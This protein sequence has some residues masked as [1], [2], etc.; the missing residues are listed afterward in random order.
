MHERSNLCGS[1]VNPG[2]ENIN[3]VE[4]MLDDCLEGTRKTPTRLE[5]M[6]C[7]DEDL[8]L[9]C[10]RVSRLYEYY[11]SIDILMDDLDM[12][13][14]NSRVVARCLERHV[15]RIEMDR[16][17]YYKSS[18]MVNSSPS[19]AES[20][21][22]CP[23]Y[24]LVNSLPVKVKVHLEAGDVD[25]EYD[26]LLS[27]LGT[28]YSDEDLGIVDVKKFAHE[29]VEACEFY[30]GELYK[31]SMEMDVDFDFVDLESS[32]F[33]PSECCVQIMNERLTLGSV[34]AVL[35]M[36]RLAKTEFQ[37]FRVFKSRSG[38]R[39]SDKM[40]RFLRSTNDA[41]R[42]VFVDVIKSR[43]GKNVSCVPRKIESRQKRRDAKESRFVE[44][45]AP[46]GDKDVVPRRKGRDWGVFL[47]VS[48]ILISHVGPTAGPE[49]KELMIGLQT[50]I[51]LLKSVRTADSWLGVYAA[52]TGFASMM[53]F[54]IEGFF[55]ML[56]DVPAELGVKFGRVLKTEPMSFDLA[57]GFDDGVNYHDVDGSYGYVSF[58]K[59]HVL[60]LNITPAVFKMRANVHPGAT[61]ATRA[62][63]VRRYGEPPEGSEYYGLSDGCLDD[64]ED[65]GSVLLEAPKSK[66]FGKVRF[67]ALYG[68]ME[69]LLG[70]GMSLTLAK[71]LSFGFDPA[72]LLMVTRDSLKSSI[73][74]IVELLVAVLRAFAEFDVWKALDVLKSHFFGTDANELSAFGLRLKEISE[75]D[76]MPSLSAMA[77]LSIIK[78]KVKIIRQSSVVMDK[79]E[80][81]KVA[82][83]MLGQ[84]DAAIETRRLRHC[85]GHVKTPP[86]LFIGHKD[87]RSGKSLIPIAIAAAIGSAFNLPLD[88]TREITYYPQTGSEYYEGIDHHHMAI[89]RDEMGSL[90][91]DIDKNIGAHAG[92][93][94]DLCSAMPTSL[95]MAFEGKGKVTTANIK[96]VTVC[97]NATAKKFCEVYSQRAAILGRGVWVSVVTDPSI[98]TDGKFDPIKIKD[99]T[100]AELDKVVYFEL[101]KGHDVPHKDI[102]WTDLGTYTMTGFIQY[103]A[104]EMRRSCSGG[105]KANV[106]RM[107]ASVS[108][109]RVDASKP[110]VCMKRTLV[111][112]TDE[113]EVMG[114][115]DGLVFPNL[116]ELQTPFGFLTRLK[117]KKKEAL[118]EPVAP[119]S[120]VSSGVSPPATP[121]PESVSVRKGWFLKSRKYLDRKAWD[122]K[123][124]FV[125]SGMN[126]A[127]RVVAYDSWT[128]FNLMVQKLKEYAQKALPFIAGIGL[129]SYVI[130]RQ[131]TYDS[132][133]H[134]KK[135]KVGV[136]VEI[137]LPQPIRKEDIDKIPEA[138]LREWAGEVFRV[139]PSP[140]EESRVFSLHNSGVMTVS[141]LD[142]IERHHV[143]VQVTPLDGGSSF[144]QVCGYVWDGALVT[145]GH[146][147][148]RDCKRAR[149]VAY[150]YLIPRAIQDFELDRKHWEFVDGC[151]LVVMRCVLPPGAKDLKDVLKGGSP[152]V[153]DRAIL[154]SCGGMPRLEGTIVSMESVSYDLPDK[155]EQTIDRCV[156]TDIT[157]TQPGH[158]G[159]VLVA[160]TK[161]GIALA[162]VHFGR[163]KETGGSM[164]SYVD[165]E[166]LSRV[167]KKLK[168]V[169]LQGLM[170]EDCT[171][172]VISHPERVEP[173]Y[174]DHGV[175]ADPFFAKKQLFL[176][177]AGV[178]G[179]AKGGKSR[180][181]RTSFYDS[182]EPLLEEACG[183]VFSPAVLS[184][185]YRYDEDLDTNRKVSPYESCLSYDN[186]PVACIPLS[187]LD[188][189][190]EGA[191]SVC[192]P[193][194]IE[195]NSMV[196]FDEALNSFAT[197]KCVDPTTGASM[198][199]PGKKGKFMVE[200]AW[201]GQTVRVARDE[202]RE[203]S[204]DI[205]RRLLANE[206]PCGVSKVALKDEVLKSKKIIGV[207]TRAVH[208]IA[209]D[210][211]NNNRMFFG[212]TIEKV[213][214]E[215]QRVF[216]MCFTINAHGKD[217]KWVYNRSVN[218]EGGR[219]R[220]LCADFEKFDVHHQYSVLVYAMLFFQEL[221]CRLWV[222]PEK[223]KKAGCLLL[224]L[225]IRRLTFVDG[226][227]VDSFMGGPSG[228]L[229][230]VFFNCVCQMFYWFICWRD[231]R[232][233]GSF[234][235][236]MKELAD[237]W[238]SLGDD[239]SLAIPVEVS[240]WF[241]PSKIVES[242]YKRCGQKITGAGVK[243]ELRYDD[244][245]VFLKRTFRED[246]ER[247]VAP[248]LVSSLLKSLLYLDPKAGSGN[249]AMRNWQVLCMVHEE[250]LFHD[251]ETRAYLRNLVAKL[252]VEL[253]AKYRDVPFPSDE[254]LWKRFDEGSMMLWDRFGPVGDA[255][256]RPVV[257]GVQHIELQC[258]GSADRPLVDLCW[259]LK[260]QEKAVFAGHRCLA[261]HDKWRTEDSV[262]PTTAQG[263]D[264]F[265]RQS[266]VFSRSAAFNGNDKIVAAP[267]SEVQ[268]GQ[269]A[270]VVTDDAIEDTAGVDVSA[271]RIIMK[272]NSSTSSMFPFG[273]LA[274][275]DPFFERPINIH[276]FSI[277]S[278]T[279]ESEINP[280][281]EYFNNDMVFNRMYGFCNVRFDLEITI[282]VAPSPY[283]YGLCRVWWF[284]L[285][286][287]TQFGVPV[288][289]SYTRGSQC[290]G[291]WIDFA[292]A[293][294]KSFVIKWPYWRDAVDIT[295]NAIFSDFGSLILT[296]VVP[297]RRVDSA[298]SGIIPLI[299][300]A[301]A[302]NMM[303][304]GPTRTEVQ[305]QSGTTDF[306]P[307][308]GSLRVLSKAAN[309]VS[310]IPF[311][312][313]LA[314]GA[315]AILDGMAT[316]AAWFGFSRKLDEKYRMIFRP[317][318][319]AGVD[320]KDDA[321]SLS[322]SQSYG[323][324]GNPAELSGVDEDEMSLLYVASRDSTVGFVSWSSADA[325]D[326]EIFRTCVSPFYCT[327]WNGD[328]GILYKSPCAVGFVAQPFAYWRGT[329]IFSFRIVCSNFH[330]G[331]I[332]LVYDPAVAG[333]AAST[334]PIEQS[335]SC[336]LEVKPGAVVEMEIGWS[337]S[338]PWLFTDVGF[339]S[340]PNGVGTNPNGFIKAYV[341]GQLTSPLTAAEAYIV[342]SVRAGKDFRVCSSR[343]LP[344]WTTDQGPDFVASRDKK[345]VKEIVKTAVD[346]QSAIVN[347]VA[348]VGYCS[349]GS[350]PVSDDFVDQQTFGERIVSMRALL[351]RYQYL[352]DLVSDE[353]GTAV[354]S[355][356][357]FSTSFPIA[358]TMIGG[359]EY[360][361]GDSEANPVTLQN[362]TLFRYFKSL[363]KGHRGGTRIR[364]R[365][366]THTVA[367]VTPPD[368][369]Y[370]LVLSDAASGSS[371]DDISSACIPTGSSAS[372]VVEEAKN[373][374][375]D[376]RL[377]D[378]NHQRFI[379]GGAFKPEPNDGFGRFGLTITRPVQDA[380]LWHY[381]LSRAIDEDFS[382]IGFCGAPVL[383][384]PHP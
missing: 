367:G 326:D 124:Y 204:F 381:S 176:P 24:S 28:Y 41:W 87:A 373:Q 342:C 279:V 325:L 185:V 293:G 68:L 18:L 55:D 160:E 141:G 181:V 207:N 100:V 253:S 180:L 225:V 372:E 299:V 168:G 249:I 241:T 337:N 130:S 334:A 117:K 159:R 288:S 234:A 93:L 186:I 307:V 78:T 20:V 123:R 75:D 56:G 369:I 217:W 192:D 199:T 25:S 308:S 148:P 63:L 336:I 96:A 164:S 292:Q 331:S 205:V 82:D 84:L 276:S 383:Q 22:C 136:D 190:L 17:S 64:P 51:Q 210:E 108:N 289:T 283:Q 182:V 66:D 323:I 34:V 10:E 361:G 147:L 300:R 174:P 377:P 282:R 384:F 137:K 135:K 213:Y 222:G 83:A 50:L 340:F 310:E 263:L 344:N 240:L 277:D 156:K 193:E 347:N 94:L 65:T 134:P 285:K 49:W 85:L 133:D 355:D 203:D 297:M 166:K 59:S 77:E 105:D 158:C 143:I 145:V 239:C 112:K 264:C 13:D 45:Q 72:A 375:A 345:A 81:V 341:L 114:A 57:E 306:K 208:A 162:G 214:A 362:A 371:V 202:L 356:K 187:S 167:A 14:Y 7:V 102:Q 53:D 142:K 138:E 44:L 380:T 363:Y 144:G 219:R 281:R 238:N 54:S 99:K 69:T 169:E 257:A 26:D 220:A 170:F 294:A 232:G 233:G 196:G 224:W 216:G 4:C 255:T 206:V 80:L 119:V 315:A 298:S 171:F 235:E 132:D 212:K 320:S 116:I 106:T 260:V 324:M 38:S 278:S 218:L 223:V 348:A 95:N 5:S 247:L 90:N 302:I 110:P 30:T 177:V 246:G 175:F 353:A 76:K 198:A 91:Q 290:D 172:G 188:D 366:L 179:N 360:F 183:D 314:K 200:V 42:S 274:D 295:E 111:G 259:V 256:I 40:V 230:T 322:Y 236:F 98:H 1:F 304:A 269:V 382:F 161:S 157:E 43:T 29:H 338:A 221:F 303:R 351:K 58:S 248:L 52:I 35:N 270:T 184:S 312:G 73:S 237:H 194:P 152:S 39:A 318:G 101:A 244:E 36:P 19:I 37:Q 154:L 243:G 118:T 346:L 211:Y 352:G 15:E 305:L 321:L 31:L 268:V 6:S 121:K 173:G 313:S 273:E 60:G 151:D 227:W 21:L 296:P 319:Y 376:F 343:V 129:A 226:A 16:R 155:T 70:A 329:L 250:A 291:V 62:W 261:Q 97:T 368:P 339:E 370:R 242:M 275:Y 195:G 287:I 364:V 280:F 3:S 215:L 189:C 107:F 254:V 316:V 165:P 358:E 271:P 11:N 47:D 328:G 178:G 262:L 23:C 126:L 330:S 92:S 332:R 266:M 309:V 67:S 357:S 150:S 46:P 335:R 333:Y 103:A 9:F 71:V 258:A 27:D 74:N 88:V 131:F 379:P 201:E 61:W 153:G 140:L 311:V 149:V 125:R 317:P 197:L 365:K 350:S 12:E 301:R 286:S 89:H 163:S 109:V 229:F 2:V 115:A 354:V 267:L 8:L 209:L 349:A 139:R 374:I 86:L 128:E 79:G 359:S 252:K 113:I 272:P 245:A 265:D 33:E 327:T 120:S 284:P 191:L 231:V 228:S 146:V 251:E 122:T 32:T 48:S 104:Y 378:Y 127:S